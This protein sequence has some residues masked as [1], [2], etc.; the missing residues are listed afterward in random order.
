MI[1][2]HFQGK[3]LLLYWDF[4][5]TERICWNCGLPRQLLLVY[6]VSSGKLTGFKEVCNN[7]E[8]VRKINGQTD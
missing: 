3:Q 4:T 6:N 2:S 1:E 7:D 5:G 8:E